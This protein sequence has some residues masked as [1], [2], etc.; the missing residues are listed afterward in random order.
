MSDPWVQP[1]VLENEWVRL[2]PV[3]ERHAEDLSRVATLD[4]FRHFVTLQPVSCDM[5]GMA[6]FIRRSLLVPNMLP[7]A[8]IEVSSGRAVGMTSYL[9]IRAAHL[10]LEIGYTWLAPEVRGTK[11]NPA[12]K[13]LQL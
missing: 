1:V 3:A 5:E 8:T 12:A 7:F 6:D 10:G 11:V 2:E 13:L 4:T 9:D